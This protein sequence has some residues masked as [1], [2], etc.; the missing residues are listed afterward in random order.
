MNMFARLVDITTLAVDAI[1]NAANTD[2][3]PGGGVCGAI[4][5][6]A[7]P[8]LAAAC[9]RL[10]PCPTGEA[11][12]TPGFRLPARFVI[13]AVGP[14]WRGGHRG[15]AE[16]LASAYRSAATIAAQMH[17]RSVAFPAI[18]TGIYGFPLPLATHVAVTTL[19]EAA[20]RETSVEEVTFACF[21]PEAIQAYA[22]EGVDVADSRDQVSDSKEIR[23]RALLCFPG[24]VKRDPAI[25][26]WMH[27]HAGALGTI[28]QRWF[29]IMRGCGD[30]VRELLHDGHPT[31]CVGDAAFAYVNAFRTHVNVGFFRG[32][33]IADHEGLLEGTGR[34]MRH[35]K[36]R[37]ERAVDAT[38]L[39]KLIE[40]AYNDMKRRLEL[41]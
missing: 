13:H 15:E 6:A 19:R 28:A 16:L 23:M 37:P 9:L 11:R 34:F 17:L 41:G 12:L 39:T 10:R 22:A 5:R 35:V 32:A 30:D 33:E 3:A 27:E 4:H 21:S 18:S 1:V 36:L 14:V 26:V 24:A 38:A 7:G 8:E 31:A 25:E 29:A 40:T 20:L 2:L